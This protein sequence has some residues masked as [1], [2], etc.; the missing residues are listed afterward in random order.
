MVKFIESELNHLREEVNHMWTLV[1]AQMEL[2]SK[3]V[4]SLDR[5]LAQQ[6][7]VRERWVDAEELKI[8]SEIED[9]IA[10]YTPV[11]VD[12][13]FVL[14]MLKIN[15][16][17][18]RI[19]DYA[20]GIAKLV[21]DSSSIKLNGELVEKLCLE[22]MFR[23]VLEM[24]S[25]LKN[26]LLAEDPVAA[27]GVLGMDDRLDELK[28]ASDEILVEYAKENL[29]EMGL[30]MSLGSI[31]RKLERTGD[32]LTNIAE[33]IVFYIDAKV[34]KHRGKIPSSEEKNSDME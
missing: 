17:L 19:G 22:E 28:K 13:R 25:G 12:L 23:V 11:A 31:F 3:A 24:M 6:I 1:Y 34:L 21:K 14:A 18:E 30:C 15:N 26:A 33:E 10:L 2:A 20:N 7:V 9:F 8:D 16:D 29:E 5:N 27:T 4:L 32:H